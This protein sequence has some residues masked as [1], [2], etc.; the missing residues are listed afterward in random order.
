MGAVVARGGNA[1]EGTATEEMPYVEER[2]GSVG[3]GGGMTVTEGVLAAAE[4]K[5]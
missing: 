2:D 4:G 1:E 5:A 3:G